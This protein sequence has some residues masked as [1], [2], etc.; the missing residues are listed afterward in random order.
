MPVPEANL[1]VCTRSPPRLTT[2]NADAGA[3]AVKRRDT[4]HV[5]PVCFTTGCPILCTENGARFTTETAAARCR[6]AAPDGWAVGVRPAAA[7]APQTAPA[8]CRAAPPDGWAFG[9]RPVAALAST[10]EA[11]AATASRGIR[12][13]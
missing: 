1:N 8:R 4:F 11:I 9:V 12:R 13:I 7:F 6:V 10:P 3:L 5:A 2:R